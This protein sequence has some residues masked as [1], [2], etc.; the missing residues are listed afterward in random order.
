MCLLGRDVRVVGLVVQVGLADTVEDAVVCG[1]KVP[2]GAC[3]S[4]EALLTTVRRSEVFPLF[5]F[6]C[7]LSLSIV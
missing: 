6:C 2:S 4:S 5:L 3:L 7:V 1:G